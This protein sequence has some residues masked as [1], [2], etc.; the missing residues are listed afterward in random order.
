MRTFCINVRFG[1]RQ[2]SKFVPVLVR[3]KI[4]LF[5]TGAVQCPKNRGVSNSESH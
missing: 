5:G 2:G 4:K 1:H 3:Q